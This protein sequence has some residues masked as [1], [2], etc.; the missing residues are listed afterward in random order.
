MQSSNIPIDFL[1]MG[2]GAVATV[3][4][5]GLKTAQ[6]STH[7]DVC[8]TSVKGGLDLLRGK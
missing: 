7:L 5:R 1:Y 3:I 6:P 2:G 8:R 4:R